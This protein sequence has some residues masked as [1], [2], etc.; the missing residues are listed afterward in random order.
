VISD[1]Y[2]RPK[3]LFVIGDIELHGLGGGEIADRGVFFR[4]LFEI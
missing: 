3:A 4:E 1:R 2:E